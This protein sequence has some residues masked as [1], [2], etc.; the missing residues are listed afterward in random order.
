M[1]IVKVTESTIIAS[2]LGTSIA[3]GVFA[4]ALL[5]P[6]LINKLHGGLIIVLAYVLPLLSI[7]ALSLT[8]SIYLQIIC[9]L[10]AMLLLPAGSAVM[11]SILMLAVPKNMLGRFFATVGIIELSLSATISLGL[12]AFY[13]Y[14]GFFSTLLLALALTAG[15][16]LVLLLSENIRKIPLPDEYESYLAQLQ[17]A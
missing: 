17:K 7:L 11:E 8:N 10:P 5:A 3:V 9:L 15:C 4:G 12:S 14:F 13:D 1:H 16:V 2:F 6:K